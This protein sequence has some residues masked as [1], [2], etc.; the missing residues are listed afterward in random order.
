MSNENGGLDRRDIVKRIIGGRDEFLVV[1]GLGGAGY[2]CT[3]ARGDHDLNFCMHGA[4]GGAPIVALGIAIAQ[5]ERRV[6]AV[7]G[8]GD[9]L[10][11]LGSLATIMTKK[12]KNLS[13]VVLDN[14]HYVETG[15]QLTASG[16]GVDLAGMAKAA[17][18]P[19]AF[20]VAD[21]AEI[22]DKVEQI[23]SAPGPVFASV[24]ISS[25]QP[26]SVPK[27]RDASYMKIRFRKALLGV[28][29]S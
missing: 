11:G 21:P 7:L 1:T 25:E 29:P 6:I 24:K 18:F 26:P 17:G 20:D 19:V 12:P 23:Q 9:M 3:A 10:M 15:N 28:V 14:G 27:T 2:D 13:V 4:M 22:D 5:P 16:H 8:D